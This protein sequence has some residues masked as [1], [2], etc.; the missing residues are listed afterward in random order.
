MSSYKTI[1]RPKIKYYELLTNISEV[2]NVINCRPTNY[3]Y[4]E[5]FNLKIITLNCFLRPNINED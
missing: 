1:S 4:S 2:Y 5:D 3:K